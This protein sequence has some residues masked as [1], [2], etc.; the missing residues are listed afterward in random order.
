MDNRE[1]ERALKV[2]EKLKEEYPEAKIALKFKNPYELLVATILSAQATDKKVNEITPI[3]FQKFPDPKSLAEADEKEVEE[4]IKP[5]GFFRQKTKYIIG[6]AKVLM[7]GFGG[8]VP[9][10]I[11]ELTTLPGVARKTANIVLGAGFGIA[12]GVP[13]D[14]HVKRLSQRLGFTRHRDPVKIELDLM[15]LIPEEEWLLF[16]YLL[17]EHG[18][19]V[20]KAPKPKCS[21]CVI[22]E[23][24]PSFSI[25][26]A[27]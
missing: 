17:I 4:I 26:S 3:L 14:T 11:E 5:L 21:E 15:N 25:F 18:R 27:Q 24:C 6:A 1:R 20:C 2:I 9:Q 8:N 23:L 13:V 16:P 10:S 22:K 12:S 7:E 19:N